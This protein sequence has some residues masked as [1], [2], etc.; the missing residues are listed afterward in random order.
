LLHQVKLAC[1]AN[2]KGQGCAHELFYKDEQAKL[3][4][5]THSISAMVPEDHAKLA[6]TATSKRQA[7]AGIHQDGPAK[8][9]RSSHTPTITPTVT[10]THKLKVR[11]P[12]KDLTKT[13]SWLTKKGKEMQKKKQTQSS[14]QNWNKRLEE[15]VQYKQEHGHCNVTREYAPNPTLGN[16]VANQRRKHSGTQRPPFSEEEYD[17]LDSIGIDWKPYDTAWDKYFQQ[18]F[19]YL[20][21]TKLP[22]ASRS[23]LGNWIRHQRRRLQGKRG[24]QLPQKR[25]DKLRTLPLQIFGFPPVHKAPGAAG[26]V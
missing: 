2:H 22:P 21:K 15:L 23:E 13:K 24:K 25:I 17:K 3:T 8:R 9:L 12:I 5:N 26:L 4:T 19:T 16:W 11:R 14:L 1:T 10:A 18:L 6:S 7:E 20:K